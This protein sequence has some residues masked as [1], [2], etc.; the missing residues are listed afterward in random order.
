M[1]IHQINFNYNTE[2]SELIMPE[3]GR[4]V[5]ML[6]N[7]CKT[8]EDDWERQGFAESI[9][10]LMQIITPYNRNFEEH[11][12]KL[13]HHFFR[14]AK[15]DIKVNPP[16]GM[17]FSK[18]LDFVKPEKISYPLN[19]EKFR[20]YGSYVSEMISKAKSLDDPEKKKAFALI[21]AS[22]MKTAIRNWNKEHFI[23]DESIKEDLA[24]MSKGELRISD[25][26]TLEVNQ[27]TPRHLR[28]RNFQKGGHRGKFNN[29][30]NKFKRNNRRP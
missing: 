25:D 8:I 11:R 20:H 30:K 4:N 14:I 26:V 24:N 15:Y 29:N 19:A 22:Y 17:E 3:Y 13:W 16:V 28:N 7:V 5:Q 9:I 27:G 18:E 2:G 12:K 6:I 23:S 10:E 21:I 1:G